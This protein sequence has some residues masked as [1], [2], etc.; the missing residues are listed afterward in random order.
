MSDTLSKLQGMNIA[1]DLDRIESMPLKCFN[2]Q[3][4]RQ[5]PSIVTQS[6]LSNQH[7]LDPLIVRINIQSNLITSD[8]A[9]LKYR[10]SRSLLRLSSTSKEKVAGNLRLHLNKNWIIKYCQYIQILQ[11]TTRE[12]VLMQVFEYYY[13]HGMNSLNKGVPTEQQEADRVTVTLTLDSSRTTSPQASF[14][15]TSTSPK[16]SMA[17]HSSPSAV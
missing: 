14:Q 1:F 9:N 6:N 17:L 15:T 10:Q 2:L 13:V 7:V 16:G 5:I 8:Y 11:W 4:M 12:S 3:M